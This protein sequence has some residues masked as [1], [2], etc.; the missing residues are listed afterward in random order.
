MMG[1][2]YGF[3]IWGMVLMVLV[4]L[5]VIVLAVWF[6]GSIFPRAAGVS[7][8]Q[9][10]DRAGAASISAPEILKQRFARGEISQAEYDEMR[11][12]LNA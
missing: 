10:T 9:A 8:P 7:T 12:H 5:G 4:W 1:F 2:G 3:G 11:N 6:L